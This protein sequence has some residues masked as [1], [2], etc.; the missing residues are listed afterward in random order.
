MGEMSITKPD[1]TTY[2]FHGDG[3]VSVE[4][5]PMRM[6]DG[7]EDMKPRSEVIG[8]VSENYEVIFWFCK[9]CHESNTP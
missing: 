7:C 6:C 2:R 9:S 3:I 5:V 1:G 8:F 4:K